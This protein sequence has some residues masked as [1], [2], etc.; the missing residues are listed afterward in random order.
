MVEHVQW[1]S[2]PDKS[3]PRSAEALF[4]FLERIN[5]L[6]NTEEARQT[7]ATLPDASPLSQAVTFLT[8]RKTLYER[9]HR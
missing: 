2:W 9:Q 1:S 7:A 8:L 5:Q 6:R 4:A 3:V